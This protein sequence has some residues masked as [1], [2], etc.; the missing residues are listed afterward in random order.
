MTTYLCDDGNAEIEIEADA[1]SEAAREYVDGCQFTDI[2]STIWIDVYIQKVDDVDSRE[3]ITV[4][5]DPDVPSCAEGREHNWQS[6]Y[7]L[8][9]GIKENP[10]VWGHGGGVII[11]EVCMNCGCARRTDTWAQNPVNGIQGLE[12]VSYEERAFEI[13]N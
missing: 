3:C 1:A 8:V 10:G 9:G 7:E 4:T 11:T 2:E 12:S 6:P 13:Q 5:V